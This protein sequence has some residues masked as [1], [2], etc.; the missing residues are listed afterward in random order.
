MCT[1]IAKVGALV[2]KAIVVTT[3]G[4]APGEKRGSAWSSKHRDLAGLLP[5]PRSHPYSDCNY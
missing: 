1:G 4:T 5:T 3:G 2:V